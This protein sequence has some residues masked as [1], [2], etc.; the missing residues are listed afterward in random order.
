ME[1]NLDLTEGEAMTDYQ[2]RRERRIERRRQQKLR[3][4]ML[5][6][7]QQ[8]IDF[9]QSR[10]N[11]QSDEWIMRKIYRIEQEIQNISTAAAAVRYAQ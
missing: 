5:A 8:Q 9:L 10:I 1:T 4:K 11:W 7:K 3:R 2:T 6:A